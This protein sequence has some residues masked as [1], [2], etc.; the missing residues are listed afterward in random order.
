MSPWITDIG[1]LDAGHRHA[2]QLHLMTLDKD[3]RYRLATRFSQ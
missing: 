3:D 2:L 1:P